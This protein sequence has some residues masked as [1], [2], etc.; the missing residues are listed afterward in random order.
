VQIPYQD[1]E[2]VFYL[3]TLPKFAA[4]TR[5]AFPGVDQLPP[6]AQGMML[7]LVYN[8]GASLK[9]ERRAEMTEIARLLRKD[10][11]DLDAIAAQFESMRRLWPDLKGL[12]DRRQKEAA[13]IR[14]ADHHYAEG[15]MIRV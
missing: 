13:M 14:A 12:R 5:A 1:A 15:D 6:D 3:R 8:R 4:S 9:G 2:E 11:T 10:R 7:S